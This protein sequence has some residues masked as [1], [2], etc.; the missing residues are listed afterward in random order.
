MEIFSNLPTMT[1]DELDAKA[2]AFAKDLIERLEAFNRNVPRPEM[3]EEFEGAVPG[4]NPE[5]FMG[6]FKV[7]FCRYMATRHRIVPQR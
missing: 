1:A 6:N 2:T 3:D 4:P 7:V 5:Q